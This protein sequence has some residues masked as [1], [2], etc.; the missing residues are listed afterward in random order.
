M[1]PHP[2]RS[3]AVVRKGWSK[4]STITELKIILRSLFTTWMHTKS[5]AFS[6]LNFLFD[7]WKRFPNFPSLVEIQLHLKK[8]K[9]K[10]KEKVSFCFE[11]CS[12]SWYRLYEVG[13]ILHETFIILHTCIAEAK[14]LWGETERNY[15]KLGWYGN[16]MWFLRNDTVI[17]ISHLS[18]EVGQFQNENA[19]EEL[20][21]I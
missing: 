3:V 11:Y 6:S 21:I 5:A 20:C 12:N 15:I 16:S 1:Y 18:M 8:S 19:L 17:K 2:Q 9:I 7:Y 10:R 4:V 14:W 13:V